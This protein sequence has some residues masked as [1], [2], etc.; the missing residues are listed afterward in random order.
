LD[1]K[2]YRCHAVS[3]GGWFC[4]HNERSLEIDA[5]K[6]VGVFNFRVSNGFAVDE[7]L[8]SYITNHSRDSTASLHNRIALMTADK[9]LEDAS[10][11]FKA[12]ELKQV[13]K[14]SQKKQSTLDA[15][16]T[17]D[18]ELSAARKRRKKLSDELQRLQQELECKQRQHEADVELVDIFKRK[19]SRNHRGLPFRGLGEAKM[20]L[21]LGRHITTAKELLDCDGTDPAIKE[22]WKDIVQACCDS[23]NSQ[24]KRLRNQ[25]KDLTDSNLWAELDVLIHSESNDNDPVA[26]TTNQSARPWKPPPFSSMSHRSGCNAR[27]I[28]KSSID[29]LITSDFQ[30]RK[31]IQED[32][33]RGTQCKELMKIDWNY[34]LAPKIKVCTGRGQS[35]SPFKSCITTR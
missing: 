18:F 2:K 29:R 22:S 19:S 33:M 17:T 21:L 9:H 1:T 34:K 32:K 30:C 7:C 4:G 14:P 15:F 3:C 10:F 6:L 27:C 11:Y 26:E 25:I 5:R 31:P 35:F 16:L 23:I 12:I 24:I 13:K 8:Y 28:P 20:L